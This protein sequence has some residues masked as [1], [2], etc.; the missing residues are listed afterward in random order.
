MH[1]ALAPAPATLSL[2]VPNHPFT[3]SSTLTPPHPNPGSLKTHLRSTPRSPDGLRSTIVRAPL[4]CPRSQQEDGG[5]LQRGW[6]RRQLWE[7]LG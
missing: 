1:R 7:A 5:G 4:S 2:W 6:A 3:C